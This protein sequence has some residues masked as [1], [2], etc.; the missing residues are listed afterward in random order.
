MKATAIGLMIIA[1]LVTMHACTVRA[2]DTEDRLQTGMKQKVEEVVT[3]L[4][5]YAAF[6]RSYRSAERAPD[7]RS[8]EEMLIKVARRMQQQARD[9]AAKAEAMETYLRLERAVPPE[10]APLTPNPDLDATRQNIAT[11]KRQIEEL[12]I[13]RVVQTQAP[14]VA[15]VSR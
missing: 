10:T 3:T 8:R 15:S 13:S 2:N 9:L 7:G 5:M 4:D 12:K 6:D 14:K 1:T 11:L